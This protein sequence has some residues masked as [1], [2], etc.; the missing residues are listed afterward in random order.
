MYIALE[1]IDG[2]GKTSISQRLK[3]KLE[4]NDFNVMLVQEPHSTYINNAISI[5]KDNNSPFEEQILSCLF[6]ADRLVLLSKIMEFD[7]IIISDR[8]KFSSYAYQGNLGYNYE[9]NA[10]MVNPN[11]I[12]YLDAPAEVAAERYEGTDKFENIEF[13]KQVRE[14]YR[15]RI[16]D[17]A[18]EDHINWVEVNATRKFEEVFM[19]VEAIVYEEIYHDRKD[20]KRIY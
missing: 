7:G 20:Y 3:E 18:K 14:N 6:A 8:S 15:G 19:Y 1:G 10:Y 17:L 9:V 2:T 11:L 13:L 16:R 12:I 4:K 5:V